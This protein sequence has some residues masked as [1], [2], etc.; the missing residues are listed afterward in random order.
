[1]AECHVDLIPIEMTTVCL[2]FVVPQNER[3]LAVRRVDSS[4]KN[5]QLF[6]SFQL[7]QMTNILCLKIVISIC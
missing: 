3:I 6:V 1:M 4:L 7:I 5:K 2:D